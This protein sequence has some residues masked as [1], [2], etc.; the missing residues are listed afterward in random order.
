MKYR[1]IFK[2]SCMN[3]F[4]FTHIMHTTFTSI[5]SNYLIQVQISET[6]HDRTAVKD[7]E[8]CRDDP[9]YLFPNTSYSKPNCQS[10]CFTEEV[11]KGC[12]CLPWA[13][14]NDEEMTFDLLLKHY[15]KRN[16]S[17]IADDALCLSISE[18]TCMSATYAQFKRGELRTCTEKC[19]NPCYEKSYTVMVF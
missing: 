2:F 1:L 16:H 14:I 11:W 10:Q 17:K 7:L 4:F 18:I 15:P 3:A 19:I 6:V 9:L 13:L 8:R 12:S 5:L